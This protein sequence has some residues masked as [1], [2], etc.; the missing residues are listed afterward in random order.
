MS[1]A[2]PI[3]DRRALREEGG[4]RVGRHRRGRIGG[5]RLRSALKVRAASVAWRLSRRWWWIL[6]A[7]LVL[8]HGVAA[9][10]AHGATA[11]PGDGREGGTRA[12]VSLRAESTV[13]GAAIRLGDIAEV[14]SRDA[15]LAQRLRAVEVARAPLPGLARSLDLPYIVAR[16]RHERIET[17]SLL[18]DAPPTV[19]VTAESQRVGGADL[20][21]AV[22]AHVLA[23][24]KADAEHLAVQATAAPADLVLPAGA[25]QLRVGDRPLPDQSTSVS[26]PVEA[27]VD[28]VLVRTVSVPVRVTALFE[29]LVVARPVARHAPLMS[30]D[31]RLERREVLAGQEPLRQ[32]AALAGRRAVRNLA[33]GELVLAGALELPPLVRRGDIVA[34]TAEGRGLRAVTRAEAKEEGKAGQT[35]RVRNLVSG[36]EV[37]GQVTGEGVV[38]VAF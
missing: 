32:A 21:A 26:L 16:L 27:W 15:V 9:R 12:V 1:G 38:R 17:E 13:R 6:A 3:A 4:D 25:L 18:F 36:R 28:G 11:A 20:V 19:S 35:I 31:V 29:V 22:R 37:Y 23:A 33:P 10:L 7:G 34:L 8:S 2:G 14:R 24:R 30:E 5:V